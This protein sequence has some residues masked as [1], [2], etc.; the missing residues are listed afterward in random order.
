MLQNAFLKTFS[1]PL[2]LNLGMGLTIGLCRGF[3]CIIGDFN[4]V[5]W[6]SKKSAS[7]CITK[8]MT[9]FNNLIEEMDLIDIPMRTSLFSWSRTRSSFVASKFDRFLL[10]KHWVDFFQNVVVNR[11]PHVTMWIFIFAYGCE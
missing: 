9:I 1:Q 11:L 3:W 2:L 10:F 6:V 4:V 5:R 8:S 7:R